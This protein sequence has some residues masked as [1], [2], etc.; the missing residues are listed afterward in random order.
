MPASGRYRNGQ[1]SVAGC[2]VGR[3]VGRVDASPGGGA[4]VEGVDDRADGEDR[5]AR[6]GA[7]VGPDQHVPP[8]VS[9]SMPAIFAT[10]H[11]SR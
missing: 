3:R 8:N 7:G 1:S 4:A 9:A 5:R 2:G 11:G 10:S 6:V